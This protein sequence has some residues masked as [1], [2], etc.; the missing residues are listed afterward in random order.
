MYNHPILA[1]A[2][3]FFAAV[4]EAAAGTGLADK[5]GPLVN[6]GA[7]GCV[8]FWFLLKTDPRLRRIEEAIDRN[9]RANLLAVLSMNGVPSHVKKQAEAI[10]GELDK[11]SDRRANRPGVGE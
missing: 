5:W 1:K 4:G 3:L 6:L 11:A 9:S 7:I 10:I 2:M 8:L